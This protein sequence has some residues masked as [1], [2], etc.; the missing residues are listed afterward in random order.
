VAIAADNTVYV[1]DAG[2]HRIQRFTATG[3]FLGKWGAHL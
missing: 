3:S 2:N 1:A